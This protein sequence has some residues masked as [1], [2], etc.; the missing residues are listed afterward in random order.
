MGDF[1]TP[2]FSQLWRYRTNNDKIINTDEYSEDPSHLDEA[3]VGVPA[4][5]ELVGQQPCAELPVLVLDVVF[6]RRL[7]GPAQL[8]GLLQVVLV[9]LDLLVVVLL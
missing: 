5:A 7:T 1:F 2:I 9:G 4:A 3:L 8:V 6:H